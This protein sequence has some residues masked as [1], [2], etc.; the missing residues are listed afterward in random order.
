MCRKVKAWFVAELWMDI[1]INPTYKLK[2]SAMK[3]NFLIFGP[4]LSR[5]WPWNRQN[6]FFLAKRCA[7]RCPIHHANPKL[8]SLISHVYSYR[9]R[10]GGK[11]I[12]RGVAVVMCPIHH[13]NPMPQSLISRVY[14]YRLR[15]GGKQIVSICW[16]DMAIN[17]TYKVKQSAMKYNFL[18]FG[19]SLSR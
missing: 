16:I 11:Q 8:Q 2:Q 7:K 3:F 10:Q 1:A 17:P 13:A 6:Q 5:K 4:S 9:S 12:V 19:P 15:Q 18:I 14:S